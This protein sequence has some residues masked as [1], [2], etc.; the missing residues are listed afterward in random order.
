M[1]VHR[2]GAG[3]QLCVGHGQEQRRIDPVLAAEGVFAFAVAP[4]WR[5]VRLASPNFRPAEQG[6]SG[7]GRRLGFAVTRVSVLDAEGEQEV[8]LATLGDGFYPVEGRG[9]R[10]SDGDGALPPSASGGLHGAG[11]LVVRGFSAPWIALDG[12][13]P[14]RGPALYLAGDSYPDDAY[15]EAALFAALDPFFAAGA[16]HQQ[17]LL[18]AGA[19]THERDIG[20]RL[21]RLEDVLRQQAAPDEAV[22]FGRSSGARV[23]TLCA[24]SHEAGRA[25]AAVVCVGYP[26]GAPGQPVEA[27]RVAHLARLATPTLILQGRDDPYGGAEARQAY[28]L[29]PSVEWRVIE[30]MHELHLGVAAWRGLARRILLFLAAVAAAR[31]Q[32]QEPGRAGAGSGSQC[33][34]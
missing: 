20:R 10:W 5:G 4:H 22:L 9:W 3:L 11:L 15:V 2:A 30:A 8:L 29:S 12:G 6:L 28:A 23:A 32:R 7:D 24:A 17:N 21:A 33:P 16:I 25:V 18:P 19:P 1:S 27:A 13:R 14:I 26:F 31:A 34:G